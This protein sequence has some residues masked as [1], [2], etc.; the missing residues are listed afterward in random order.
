LRLGPVQLQFVAAALHP[1][2]RAKGLWEG[3]AVIV[4]QVS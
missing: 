2:A 3:F 4:C 1:D